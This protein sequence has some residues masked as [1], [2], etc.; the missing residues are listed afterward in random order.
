M[1]AIISRRDLSEIRSSSSLNELFMDLAPRGMRS[2]IENV[3][4]LFKV[5]IFY[6]YKITIKIPSFYF[7]PKFLRDIYYCLI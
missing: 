7:L 4:L 2:L 3:K 5:T 1:T 6:Y